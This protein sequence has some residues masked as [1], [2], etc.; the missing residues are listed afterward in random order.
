M[1]KPPDE[2]EPSTYFEYERARRSVT[3]P[4]ED[5][6]SGAAPLP[7]LPPS[8]PW[9]HDPVPDE[10]TINREEDGDAFGVPIDQA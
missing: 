4:G 9:H 6:V 5:A 10:P 7:R 8:S 1:P 2:P 3:N